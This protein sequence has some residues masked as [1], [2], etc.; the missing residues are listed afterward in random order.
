M[1]CLGKHITLVDE[2]RKGTTNSATRQT[3]LEV[4]IKGI[5]CL[6]SPPCLRKCWRQPFSYWLV[7]MVE[8]KEEGVQPRNIAMT[9]PQHAATGVQQWATVFHCC[10]LVVETLPACN[11][12]LSAA[13]FQPCLET[14]TISR[15]A[16]EWWRFVGPKPICFAWFCFFVST[17]VMQCSGAWQ[18][19]CSWLGR[20]S[21]DLMHKD[22][23]CHSELPLSAGSTLVCA[24]SQVCAV[25]HKFT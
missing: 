20:T 16:A 14:R 1:V 23:K 11:T 18:R 5:A 21:N 24:L 15:V 25:L 6:C 3:K 2:R 17:S 10:L 7:A 8:I 22:C 12:C 4:I 13:T 19:S 9:Y